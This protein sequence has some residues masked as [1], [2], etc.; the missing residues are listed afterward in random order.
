MQI[1]LSPRLEEIAKLIPQA[2]RVADIGTDHGY[3][4]I[5]LLQEGIVDRLIVSDI[6][7]EPLKIA[8]NNVSH[9]G[10]SDR[11]EFRLGNGLDILNPNEVDLVIISGMGGILISDILE[12]G[13]NI[14]K[15]I[16]ALVLQPMT[17]Q[18][19]LR[20]YLISRNFTIEKDLL[21]KESNRIYEIIL[22]QVNKGKKIKVRDNLMFEIGFHLKSNPK[23]ISREFINRKIRIER[24]II[25]NIEK[26]SISKESPR[27]KNCL[28]KIKKLEGVLEWLEG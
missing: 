16:G 26:H 3:M 8:K 10:L 4:A 7:K 12:A 23:K 1:K 14:I 27:Y 21:V 17:K 11:V 20:K 28:K 18:K 15:D 9:Y 2:S 22:T 6:N 24:Q 19:H 5:Y 13:A 25:Q